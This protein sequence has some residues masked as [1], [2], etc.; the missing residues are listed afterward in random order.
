MWGMS[1]LYV[2]RGDGVNTRPG[3]TVCAWDTSG[4][5]GTDT[6]RPHT[7]GTTQPHLKW[8]SGPA[9][10]VDRQWHGTQGPRR[11]VVAKF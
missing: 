8:P 4:L 3:D 6:E 1:E 2:C 9:L 7:A 10:N 5:V 11:K